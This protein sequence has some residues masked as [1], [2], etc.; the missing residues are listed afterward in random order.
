MKCFSKI[1]LKA[2]VVLAKY[3][4]IG[5]NFKSHFIHFKG[6]AC[7][8]TGDNLVAELSNKWLTLVS[9]SSNVWNSMV[10]WAAVLVLVWLLQK[11]LHTFKD[12]ANGNNAIWKMKMVMPSQ[13]WNSKPVVMLL[14]EIVLIKLGF[15]RMP[16]VIQ[17]LPKVAFQLCLQS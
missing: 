13:R 10:P 17:Y 8:W 5:I 12:F 15:V 14:W 1:L 11:V 4:C 6:K 9:I 7:R 3:I 2:A 16:I